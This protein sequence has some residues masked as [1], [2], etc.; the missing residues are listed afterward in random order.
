M[1]QKQDSSKDRGLESKGQGT[2]KW[3]RCGMASQTA[4][5]K[6]KEWGVL[7]QDMPKKQYGHNNNPVSYKDIHKHTWVS[8]PVRSLHNF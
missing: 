5:E 2:A 3:Q 7:Y 4:Q 1:D 8:L 6:V